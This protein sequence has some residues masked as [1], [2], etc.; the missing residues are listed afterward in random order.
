MGWEARTL[1]LSPSGGVG[2]LPFLYPYILFFLHHVR[3]SLV[4]PRS[5]GC[6]CGELLSSRQAP[7]CLSSPG[8]NF[9]TFYM[10]SNGRGPPT[11]WQN[12]TWSRWTG[13]CTLRTSNSRWRPSSGGRSTIGTSP[14]S[15]CMSPACLPPAPLAGYEGDGETRGAGLCP[16]G[17]CAPSAV[18][19]PDPAPC[20]SPRWISCRCA[21]LS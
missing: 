14:P 13:A 9:P 21:S 12:A 16:G 2:M 19:P 10:P 8:R 17:Q 11:T 18:L 5:Q 15:R 4:I 6:V 20:S 1:V 3:Q 7:P